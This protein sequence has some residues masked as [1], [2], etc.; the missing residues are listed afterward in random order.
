[1]HNPLKNSLLKSHVSLNADS[2]GKQKHVSPN[3]REQLAGKSEAAATG[4]SAG[5]AADRS[6]E[7]ESERKA[8]R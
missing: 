3:E 2:K 1:V 8:S 7:I 6:K 5:V 4:I